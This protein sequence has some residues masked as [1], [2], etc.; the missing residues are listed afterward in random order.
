[1]KTVIWSREQKLIFSYN[2]NYANDILFPLS[3]GGK[4]LLN[5]ILGSTTLRVDAEKRKSTQIYNWNSRIWFF[6]MRNDNFTA[7]SGGTCWT[8]G[9]RNIVC[10][11]TQ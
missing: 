9:L 11:S 2:E 6:Y 1:M 5:S 3:Q 4:G 8:A 10:I 7:I